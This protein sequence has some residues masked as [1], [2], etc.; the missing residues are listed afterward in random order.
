MNS[1]L[2][3]PNSSGV[4]RIQVVRRVRRR[5]AFVDTTVTETWPPRLNTKL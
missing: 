5:E 3:Q 1:Q 2:S 4:R